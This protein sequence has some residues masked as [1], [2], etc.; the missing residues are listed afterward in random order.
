VTGPHPQ[1]E[2][3]VRALRERIASGRLAPG[4]RVPSDRVIAAELGTSSITVDAAR[5][6]LLGTG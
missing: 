6:I 1:R 3:V 5:T 4:A 2:L